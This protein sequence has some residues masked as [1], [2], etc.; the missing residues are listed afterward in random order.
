M[1][2]I[3][4]KIRRDDFGN[5]VL[6]LEEVQSDWHQQGRKEGYDNPPL[7][8]RLFGKEM[9]LT[10][11]RTEWFVQ[12]EDGRTSPTNAYNRQQAEMRMES[13]LASQMAGGV[14]DAPFKKNYGPH[15]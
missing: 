8:G 14:P 11:Q 13:K 12:W 10:N 5:K 4:S 9:T 6:F 2:S 3:R 15:F 7:K 1:L